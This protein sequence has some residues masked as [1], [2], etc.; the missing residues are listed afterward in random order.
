MTLQS[1][2]PDPERTI[3]F[4]GV[5]GAYSHLAC[6]TAYP[7]L[8]PL[9][10]ETFEEA[11]AAVAEGRAGLGMIPVENSVAGRVAD[12]HHLLPYSDLHIVAEHFQRINHHLLAV[13]E[14]TPETLR[15]VHSHVHALGQC[16]N[17]IR[18]LG[19]RA[20]MAADTAGAAAEIAQTGDPTRAAIASAL[21]GEIYGLVSLKANIEDADHNTTR[22]F[23]M[24]RQAVNPNP[25]RGPVVTSF[26][27]TVRNVPA[28]LYKALGGFATNGVNMTKLESYL[29]DGAFVAA[30]FYAE[31]EA[32]PDS[33]GLRLALEE[34]R[35]FSRSLRILGVYPAHPTRFQSR[36]GSGGPDLRSLSPSALIVGL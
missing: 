22:F 11:F 23:V 15:T 5:A 7:E 33:A 21:A 34:L 24:A 9:A 26:L 1:L 19:L 14:A 8:S 29:V 13:P 17:A 4:Q 27:F 16:R 32:H 31:V 35:F 2:P 12:I 25:A 6:L 3:A 30:Q 36:L 28:A 10:C 18:A 20:V